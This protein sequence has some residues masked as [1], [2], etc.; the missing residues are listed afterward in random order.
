MASTPTTTTL[1]LGGAGRAK[2]LATL[3]RGSIATRLPTQ[4]EQLRLE[5]TAENPEA[6]V[7]PIVAESRE[8]QEDEPE[9]AVVSK[10]GAHGML[11]NY[12]SA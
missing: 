4:L 2:L 12:N 9:A 5:A 10:L 7:Q 11:N 1:S 8:E 6:T 3:G